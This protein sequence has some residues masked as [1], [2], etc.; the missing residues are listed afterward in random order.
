MFCLTVNSNISAEKNNNTF[1]KMAIT[2]KIIFLHL[3]QKT[4]SKKCLT[5]VVNPDLYRLSWIFPDSCFV[6]FDE[7]YLSCFFLCAEVRGKSGFGAYGM[8]YNGLSLSKTHNK[9][10]KSI[11][12]FQNWNALWRN[13]DENIPRIYTKS[14]YTL[15]D[16]EKKEVKM[17]F[18]FFVGPKTKIKGWTFT[19]QVSHKIH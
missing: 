11:Q 9:N 8:I 14:W 3:S 6:F 19:N 7:S 2:S 4:L 17:L 1:H 18:S 10:H 5:H 13:N 12:Q 16:L 15:E